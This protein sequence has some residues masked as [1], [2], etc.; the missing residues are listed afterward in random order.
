MFIYSYILLS[1]YSN[2]GGCIGEPIKK[3]KMIH[4]NKKNKQSTN[5]QDQLDITIDNNQPVVLNQE[6]K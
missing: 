3:S 1:T 4:Q 5:P 2:M 6:K